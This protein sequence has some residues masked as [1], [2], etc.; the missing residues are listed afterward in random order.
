MSSSSKRHFQLYMQYAWISLPRRY[1]H[2]GIEPQPGKVKTDFNS[3]IISDSIWKKCKIINQF[4]Y[5]YDKVLYYGIFKMCYYLKI[6]HK[7]QT[8]SFSTY[9][10]MFVHV[11]TL[12]SFKKNLTGRK[13]EYKY[14]LLYYLKS[15]LLFVNLKIKH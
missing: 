2:K 8:M 15:K 9:F 1:K 13:N 3:K 14:R 12:N 5:K 6:L 11:R 7:K 10:K 4:G